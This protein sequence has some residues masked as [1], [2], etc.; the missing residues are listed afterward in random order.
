MFQNLSRDIAKIYDP[1]SLSVGIINEILKI[2][3]IT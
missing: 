2:N 1:A 3:W